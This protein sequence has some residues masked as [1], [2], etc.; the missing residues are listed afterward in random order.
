MI[1]PFRKTVTSPVTF[2]NPDPYIV[3]SVYL[4]PV[5]GLILSI[6]GFLYYHNNKKKRSSIVGSSSNYDVAIASHKS[7]GEF[8]FGHITLSQ[9]MLENNNFSSLAMP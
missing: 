6:T 7:G 1:R 4:P 9:I 5:P 3:T 2:P 8:F